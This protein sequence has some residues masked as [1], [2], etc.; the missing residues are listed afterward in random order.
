MSAPALT[1]TP[2]TSIDELTRLFAEH[3]FNGL[4]VVSDLRTL[5]GADLGSDGGGARMN[6]PP[7]SGNEMNRRD[8]E[9]FN[10]SLE[11]CTSGGRFLD[12]FY[13][14][15]VTSS[16][17]VAAKFANT[18]FRIQKAAVKVSLYMIMSSVE[19]KP[20][21]NIHLE[22]IA[23]RPGTAAARWTSGPTS[24]I[25]GLNVSSKRCASPTPCSARRS[26]RPGAGSCEWASSS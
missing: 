6:T 25:S 17:E 5:Q 19:Q 20:E 2:E 21:G 22:R 10:D 18:D 15:F 3:E 1:V 4:P 26:N 11:R 8:V 23:A 9:L 13:E 7:L 14:L 12:R 24:T 16:A